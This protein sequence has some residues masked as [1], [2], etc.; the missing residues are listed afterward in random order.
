[1][2]HQSISIKAPIEIVYDC[3]TDFESY[4]KFLPETKTVKIAWCDD[5]KMEVA[6]KVNLIKDISYTLLFELDP[7]REV[8]WKLKTGDFMK[9]NNGSW[10]MKAKGDHLTEAVYSIDIGFGL[11]VPQA[12]TQT[13]I[14]K[15]LPLT[16]KRFKKRAESLAKKKV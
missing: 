1:M 11:W 7:T 12:I 13:L 10:I 8:H 14:E 5:K 2:V 16:L 15:S 3:V 9:S 4:P 6:F